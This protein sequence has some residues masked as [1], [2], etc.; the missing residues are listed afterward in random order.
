LISQNFIDKLNT[1]KIEQE[2]LYM[3]SLNSKEEILQKALEALRKSFDIKAS[4]KKEIGQ[5]TANEIQMSFLPDDKE[6]TL[7]EISKIS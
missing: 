7:F 4:T 6:K 3:K 1:V 5:E 2:I